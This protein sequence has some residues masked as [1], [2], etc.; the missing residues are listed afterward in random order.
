MFHDL[1]YTEENSH[2]NENKQKINDI[3]HLKAIKK[4]RLKVRG[5]V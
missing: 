1:Y 3:A 5:T 2:Y 4:A